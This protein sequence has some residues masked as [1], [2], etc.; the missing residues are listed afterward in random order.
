MRIVKS[1]RTKRWGK[2]QALQHLLIRS[3]QAR[4]PTVKRVTENRDAARQVLTGLCGL[5]P[6]RG[7]KQL[8]RCP[9]VIIVHNH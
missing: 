9:A 6:S 7:G 5:M 3:H 1:A 4:L 2:V 8:K